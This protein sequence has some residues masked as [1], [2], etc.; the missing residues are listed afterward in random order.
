MHTSLVF[1]FLFFFL[2]KNKCIINKIKEDLDGNRLCECNC[3]CCNLLSNI[4][5]SNY[6]Y[7]AT[8]R[9]QSYEI[10]SKFSTTTD[11]L[12]LN[13]HVKNSDFL[14]CIFYHGTLSMG[15]FLNQY[16]ARHT[17]KEQC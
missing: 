14:S 17:P 7:F 4:S 3:I 5:K 15:Q 16:K 1:C 6:N 13:C 12:L 10:S 8:R 11:E 9:R 2:K